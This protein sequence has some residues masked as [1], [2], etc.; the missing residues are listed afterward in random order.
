MVL[1]KQGDTP[2]LGNE[3]SVFYGACKKNTDLLIK[4]LDKVPV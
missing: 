4:R 3:R 2:I 1:R